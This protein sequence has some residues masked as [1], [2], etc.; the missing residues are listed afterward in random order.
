MAGGI[1]TLLALGAYQ[2]RERRP[3]SHQVEALLLSHRG[4]ALSCR[5]VGIRLAKLS[6]VTGLS[7][8]QTAPHAFRRGFAVEFLRNGGDVFLPPSCRP[9][10]CTGG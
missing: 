5:G 1:C 3:C 10:E 4:E 8:D 7:S 6:K 9:A 2:R